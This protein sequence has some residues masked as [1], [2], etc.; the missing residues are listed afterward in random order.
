[1]AAEGNTLLKRYS[2]YY[3]YCLYL[4]QQQ[5]AFHHLKAF[6]FGK[7]MSKFIVNINYIKITVKVAQIIL[8]VK[9][10]HLS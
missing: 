8:Y 4:L 2:D 6:C 5:V 7:Q 1:M 9:T 10:K 3:Y